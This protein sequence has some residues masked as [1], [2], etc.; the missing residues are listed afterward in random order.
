MLI[1]FDGTVGAT[2]QPFVGVIKAETQAGFRRSKDGAKAVVE[3]LQNIFLT[4]ATRLYKIGLMLF[5]DTIKAKP[6]GRRAFV[7]DSNISVSN[8]EAAAAYFYE[9]FL[10]ALCPAMGRT[11]RPGSSTSPGS[12]CA[13]LNSSLK[14]S[15]T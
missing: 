11:K 10:A 4:P 3:F 5:E 9:G 7:F 12:S 1:V 13:G 6:D 14:K 2:A 15:G 8:R